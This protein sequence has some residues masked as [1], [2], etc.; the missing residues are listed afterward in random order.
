[1]PAIGDSGDRPTFGATGYNAGYNGWPN[2]ETWLVHLWLTNDPATDTVCRQL[3]GAVEQT[4][5][6]AA[7]ALKSLLEEESPLADQAGMY[8]DLL[9]A[10]LARVDWRAI[11]AHWRSPPGAHCVAC[12]M[13]GV[14]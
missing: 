9:T 12:A 4:V 13:S 11:A 2:H 14:R 7:E 6:E 1:M 5:G 3:V 8:A 10:A